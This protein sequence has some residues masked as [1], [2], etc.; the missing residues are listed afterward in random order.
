MRY[1]TLGRTGLSVSQVAFG[2]LFVASFATELE[3]AK[4]TVHRAVE[5]GINYFDTAPTYGNSEEVMGY[6][7]RDLAQ[8]VILSTKLGGRPSPFLPKD[9]SCLLASVEESLRLLGRDTID[10]LMIHEP[11]RPGQYDWWTN[12]QDI[13]GP[14][15]EVL[16]GLKKQGVIKALGLGGTTTTEL[17]YLCRSGKFDVVLTAYNYSLL[18]RESALEVIPAAK[19]QNMGIII[20]SPLQQGA[21]A[22]RF[23]AVM[24]DPTVYWLSKARREQYKALYAFVDECGIA[25]TELAM[26]FIISNPDVD[27]VLMGA[28]SVAE[29]ES[30]IAAIDKGPLPADVLARLD[31]IAAM[32]PFRP[33]GEPFGIGWVL[34][35]PHGYKGQGQA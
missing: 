30:N 23:D 2:G 3:E 1:Q 14:V 16:D 10:I 5:L 29:A 28:R 9:P 15:L 25:L 6:A 13:N 20:G 17:A 22:R 7:M 34:P 21:L 24:D 11:E 4:R 19:S 18:W 27:S 26:R 32:V 8:P 12:W 31:A 33:F 35:N